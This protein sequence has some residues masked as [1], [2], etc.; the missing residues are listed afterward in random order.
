MPLA[1]DKVINKKRATKTS[2]IVVTKTFVPAENTL[3][4]EKVRKAN[5]ILSKTK[6]LHPRP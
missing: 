5:E 6:L 3:F 4:P 1:K 2:T